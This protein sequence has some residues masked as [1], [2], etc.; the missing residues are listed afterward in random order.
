MKCYNKGKRNMIIF[1]KN[2]IWKYKKILILYLGI[3]AVST[4]IMLTIPM[5]FG[6]MVD[7]I[8]IERDINTL[9]KIGI[10]V[11][12]LGLINVLIEYW[13]NR[14]Y[15]TIQTN[16]AIDMSMDVIQ[17]LRKVSLLELGKYDPGYLNESINHDS[18]SIIIFF[19]FSYSSVF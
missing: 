12:G 14:F 1:C 8:T 5:L 9:I 18:N 15:V 7:I 11:L 4:I 10:V 2:Y 3:S 19:I 13:N 17:H 16:S 6:Y